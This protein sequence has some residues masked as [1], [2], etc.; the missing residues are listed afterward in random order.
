LTNYE[1]DENDMNEQDWRDLSSIGNAWYSFEG[2]NLFFCGDLSK[3]KASLAKA[4]CMVKECLL[5]KMERGL[6]ANF[7]KDQ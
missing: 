4:K 1:T 7:M 6:K 2:K 3:T 5:S